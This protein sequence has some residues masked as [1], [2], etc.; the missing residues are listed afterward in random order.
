MQKWKNH[1]FLD[2]QEGSIKSPLNTY[3]FQI[4][5]SVSSFLFCLSVINLV[6]KKEILIQYFF[7]ELIS[8]AWFSRKRT[9]ITL[10]IFIQF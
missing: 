5:F 6:L 10:R 8:A 7:A 4:F 9:E 2:V 3:P 1:F